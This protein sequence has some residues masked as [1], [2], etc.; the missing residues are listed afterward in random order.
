MFATLIVIGAAIPLKTSGEE[1]KAL[2]PIRLNPLESLSKTPTK[3]EIKQAVVFLAAN[4]DFSKPEF[5][6]FYATINCES[7]FN[8]NPPGWNDGGLAYGVAQF[9]K[10]TFYGN[11]KGDYYSAHDQLICMAQMWKIE[12]QSQ[13]TCYT[14]NFVNKNP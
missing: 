11:C 13:W 1:S 5:S 3:E 6:E 14:D 7:G 10:D 9:H 8:Y 2:Q 12:M 4:M